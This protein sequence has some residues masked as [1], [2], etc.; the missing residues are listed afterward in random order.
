MACRTA[1]ATGYDGGSRRRRQT[2]GA[3]RECPTLKATFYVKR[4]GAGVLLLALLV[5]LIPV[6]VEF[7]VEPGRNQPS[8]P[9][10]DADAAAIA[11]D[12]LPGAKPA[13]FKHHQKT[14]QTDGDSWEDDV[15]GEGEAE[16][17]AR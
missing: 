6:L 1:T 3:V 7:V 9:I 5:S 15:E 11:V 13:S 14:G 8:V 10:A 17:D 16:L 12:S 4:A 2:A